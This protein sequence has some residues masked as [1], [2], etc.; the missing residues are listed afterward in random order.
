M[1]EALSALVEAGRVY[2]KPLPPYVPPTPTAPVDPWT[3]FTEEKLDQ[4][5]ALENDNKSL[6]P[7]KGEIALAQENKGAIEKARSQEEPSKVIT[8]SSV[9]D[10]DDNP[11]TGIY[12]SLRSQ[13]DRTKKFLGLET[14][15]HFPVN[16]NPTASANATGS[17]TVFPIPKW[18]MQR[19]KKKKF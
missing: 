4:K 16:V 11:W 14:P 17:A 1:P 9:R 2:T 19:K 8:N 18:L 6:R 15:G 3:V 5:V 7:T 13:R 12:Q 10:A